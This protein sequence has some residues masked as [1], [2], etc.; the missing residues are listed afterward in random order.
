MLAMTL[1]SIYYHYVFS[2]G[3]E[4]VML[5]IIV[6]L[7]ALLTYNELYKKDSEKS[8]LKE[9]LENLERLTSQVFEKINSRFT[10]NKDDKK[11]LI[12]SLK[13]F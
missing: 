10:N 6:D 4:M 13:K 12:E 9:K 8:I 7:I 5:L 2:K 1:I 11:E 3:L